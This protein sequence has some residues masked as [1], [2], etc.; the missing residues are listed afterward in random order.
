MNGTTFNTMKLTIQI[1]KHKEKYSDNLRVGC[2][3]E[4]N[5]QLLCHS[6]DLWDDIRCLQHKLPEGS[7]ILTF[8]MGHF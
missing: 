5:P 8:Y 4:K 6:Y 3:M 2:F 1:Y 7:Y